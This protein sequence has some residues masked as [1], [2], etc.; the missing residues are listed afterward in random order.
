MRFVEMA[1]IEFGILFK[2]EKIV[3]FSNLNE[4]IVYDTTYGLSSVPITD[5]S[6]SDNYKDELK[7]ITFK[8]HL[9]TIFKCF[10]N[11]EP[12]YCYSITKNQSLDEFQ[13]KISKLSSKIEKKSSFSSLEELKIFCFKHLIK[14]SL[15][16][17]HQ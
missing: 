10:I 2:T 17:L 12:T 4:E 5:W 11:K 6:I 15:I 3:I 14:D 7:E 8:D 9:L 16:S 13:K 1:L